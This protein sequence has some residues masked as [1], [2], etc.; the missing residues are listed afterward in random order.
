[1]KIQL[2]QSRFLRGTV[3]FELGEFLTIRFSSLFRSNETTYDFNRISHVPNRTR[4]I[5]VA[6][7]I[8]ALLCAAFAIA[9]LG[10]AWREKDGALFPL[11][12]FTGLSGVCAWLAWKRYRH[13]IVFVDKSTGEPAFAIWPSTPSAKEVDQFISAL[14]ESCTRSR[15]PFG[16]SEVETVEFYIQSL[17]LL[18]NNGVLIDAEYQAAVER[19]RLKHVPAPVLSL[20]TNSK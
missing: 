2:R 10:D 5:P 17:Q 9:A 3:T 8:S 7:I 14:T 15:V 20:V 16:A 6:W 11:I 12:L 19:L 13:F 1:M 18:L 4:Y